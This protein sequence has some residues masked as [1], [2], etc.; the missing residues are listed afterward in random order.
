MAPSEDN[1]VSRFR[2]GVHLAT[3]LFKATICQPNPKK[4]YR[5]NVTHA[6]GY[7][8]CPE[9][10]VVLIHAQRGPPDC[11][12]F[13]KACMQVM[14][15]SERGDDESSGSGKLGATAWSR[16]VPAPRSA[17]HPLSIMRKTHSR[18]KKG[19][20]ASTTGSLCE[21]YDSYQNSSM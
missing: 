2:M 14:D 16:V 8:G 17:I 6:S 19:F 10:P 12:G 15:E 20:R 7:P 9:K 13:Q 4:G 1:D 5:V 21:R 3:P 11:I 18:T